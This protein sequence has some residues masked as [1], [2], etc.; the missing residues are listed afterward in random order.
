[1]NEQL[2]KVREKIN[3]ILNQYI[4]RNLA[5]TIMIDDDWITDQ[6]L[7]TTV[8]RGGETCPECKGEK[9]IYTA[10]SPYLIVCPT[11]KGTG[12]LPL[13]EKSVK[14]ALIEGGWR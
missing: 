8:K 3:G 12:A 10:G 2:A 11:C 4:I 13:E 5:E 9:S 1:M 7:N 6:I 14:D